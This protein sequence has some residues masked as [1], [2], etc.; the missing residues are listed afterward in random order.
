MDN[1]LDP[2]HLV[3]LMNGVFP[4]GGDLSLRRFKHPLHT[5]QHGIVDN[6][7]VN[8]RTK[9]VLD[10]LAHISVSRESSQVV[11]IALQLDSRNQRIRLT[12]AENKKVT[13][14]LVNH[15]ILVWRKLQN[16]SDEYAKQRTQEPENLLVKSPPIP[17]NV[18]NDLK[19][20]IFRKIYQYSLEKH[21]KRIAKW[22]AS[23]TGF[24]KKFLQCR[25]VDNLERLE[26]NLYRAAV[27]LV[28]TVRLVGRL[29][30]DT[31]NTLT[32]GEWEMLYRQSMQANEH[33]RLVLDADDGLDCEDLALEILGIP[34]LLPIPFSIPALNLTL[35]LYQVIIPGMLS[36]FD[37]LLR[38]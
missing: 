14:G 7:H 35:L 9:P 11:A 20:A 13:D 38:N 33:A 31:E 17:P 2:H 28:L 1:E 6:Y 16:L 19:V 26:W 8:V 10:A 4:G 32:S 37:V 27:T 5:L 18:A 30:G 3:A 24:I 34:F 25:A 36:S 22:W 21:M 12:V 29:G 23:F 15:L